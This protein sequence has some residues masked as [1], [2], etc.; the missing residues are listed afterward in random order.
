MLNKKANTAVNKSRLNEKFPNE[1]LFK[2]DNKYHVNQNMQ[3]DSPNENQNFNID[4]FRRKMEL[5]KCSII[6]LFLNFC[7]YFSIKSFSLFMLTVI[8]LILFG[9][10]SYITIILEKI[11]NTSNFSEIDKYLKH[12]RIFYE[13]Q[14]IIYLYQRFDYKIQIKESTKLTIDM[15]IYYFSYS[16]FYNFLTNTNIKISFFWLLFRGYILLCFTNNSDFNFFLGSF[17]NLFSFNSILVICMIISSLSIEA[18]KNR[19]FVELWGLYDSFKR[20]FHIFK[21]CLYDDFPNPIFIISRKQYEVILYKNR[22]ADKLHEKISSS[23]NK[24]KNNVNN[25]NNN[26]NGNIVSNINSNANQN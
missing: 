15:I 5:I 26:Y 19:N 4:I 8:Q 14:N 7:I 1:N 22:A 3:F 11:V 21:R 25:N 24:L 9:I 12:L 2:S 13:I 20:S 16:N 17:T 23:K 10:I 18:L 6:I